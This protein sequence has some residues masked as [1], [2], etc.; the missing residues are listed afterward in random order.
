[1][2]GRVLSLALLLHALCCAQSSQVRS[3]VPTN[4]S[5]RAAI[6]L[7]HAS[8]D[9]R[10][11]AYEVRLKSAPDD[12]SAEIG[13][14]AA[15]LQKLRESGNGAY[16]DRAAT[17]VDSMLR[18][19][20]GS[21]TTLRLQNEI[22]MQRH[23]FQAVAERA[24]DLIRFSRSDPGVWANLGDASMELGEYDSAR[25]AYVKMFALR[26]NLASYNRLAYL[27][28]VTG[29]AP[30]AIALMA[31]AVEAGDPQPQNVAWC[32]AEL[33]DIYFK[34]GNLE[35]AA[36]AYRQAVDLFPALH[37]AYAG[38]AKVEASKGQ[39]DSAI[40]YYLHAQ[41]IVPLVE[42]AGALEDL[43][44]A[45]AQPAKAQEQQALIDVIQKL[46]RVRNETTNR[47]LALLLAD[48]D[49]NLPEALHL[50]ETELPV[51]GD[52]YTWD[53]YSWVLFKNGRIA[54]A[55]AASL[56][57]LKFQT[58]E[59]VFY[60]HAREIARAAGEEEP[61]RQ[62]AA[63]LSAL[64]PQFD[65]AKTEKHPRRGDKDSLE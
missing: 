56:K 5:K 65:F 64:N 12:I 14:T 16:L 15:C 8:A 40:R 52:V 27:R 45:S 35:E 11:Q 48:H 62:Y 33:A 61:A 20:G 21:L 7:A 36:R 44:D 23:N 26:P 59:P 4:L 58:P 34:T 18:Q 32:S 6:D 28:F 31:N 39:L 53:A 10:I 55:R 43:Y 63:R 47:N 19:D 60:F 1:M 25:D 29:D 13:L 46:G 41:S 51:R 54:E 3:Q 9:E 2:N 42:Y 37:R 38:L 22:D 50:V 30:E 17:L 49:R 24:R 57:A